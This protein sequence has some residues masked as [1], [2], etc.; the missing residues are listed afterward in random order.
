[1]EPTQQQLLNRQR[2]ANTPATVTLP[3]ISMPSPVAQPISAD[4]L[5]QKQ[6][7]LNVPYTP[8]A[9]PQPFNPT[10]VLDSAKQYM[11]QMQNPQ[12]QQINSIE[13]QLTALGVETP[14]IASVRQNA[15]AQYNIQGLTKNVNDLYAKQLDLAAQRENVPQKV[16][17][18]YSQSDALQGFLDART[19]AIQ[20]RIASSERLNA[21]TLQAAQGNLASAQSLATQ[22][23]EDQFKDIELKQQNLR[24]QRQFILDAAARNEIKL[25]RAQELAIKEAE[26]KQALVDKQI[27]QQKEDKKTVE[28]FIAQAIAQAQYDG[29]PLP[30]SLIE[31]ARNA[32]TPNDALYTL[33]PYLVDYEAKA[34]A[35]LDRQY[36]EAQLGKLNA[37]ADVEKAKAIQA[38]MA[39]AGGDGSLANLTDDQRKTFF[40]LTDRYYK[41]TKDFVTVRDAYNRIAAAASD[42]TPAGD[43]AL[44]FNYMKMLDPGSTVRE[45]EFATAQNSGSAFDIVGAQ[46]NKVVAGTRLTEAQRKDFLDV[47]KKLFSSAKNQAQATNDRYTGLANDFGLPAYKIVQELESAASGA[48]N[49]DSYFLNASP[50]VQSKI[51][52][53]IMQGKSKE[54][55]IRQVQSTNPSPMQQQGGYEKNPNIFYSNPGQ[56]Q[57]TGPLTKPALDLALSQIRKE[58]GLRLT[59]Y[60]DQVGVWT[61]GYGN[62]MLNGRPVKPGDR[63]TRQ[64]ADEMLKDQAVN[65]YTNFTNYVTRDLTPKQTAALMSFEYNLGPSIWDKPDAQKIIDAINKGDFKTASA[66]LQAYNTGLD[67]KTGKRKVLP[68][69]VARR[70]REGALLNS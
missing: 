64:Q 27:A 69:L 43:L 24:E 16:N 28:G 58:E 18:V 22:A 37:E 45:G 60:Q 21:A 55:A 1:M 67:Q 57:S 66:K 31:K 35:L 39:A 62:T 4:S 15:N 44:I 34:M 54:D 42:A 33:A 20:N 61:I 12:D 53:L 25:S 48:G 6:T 26:S 41:E 17:D 9:P 11:S 32:A 56:K 8:P 63:I 23:V 36:K 70:K 68:V 5:T 3:N 10:A 52:N 14:S 40:D 47:T 65:N 49:S 7:P 13:Q 2:D 51:Y 30:Q 46:Y 29:K 19:V 59:A 50:D 38:A